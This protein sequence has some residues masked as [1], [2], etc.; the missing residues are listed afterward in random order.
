[1]IGRTIPHYHVLDELCESV[2]SVA[3]LAEDTKRG[4]EL[5]DV[6]ALFAPY[7]SEPTRP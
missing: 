5:P 7:A 2:V 4:R 6:G 1:M 3:Y